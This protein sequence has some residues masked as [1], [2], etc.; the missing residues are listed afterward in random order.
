VNII[1]ENSCNSRL[2][3]ESVTAPGPG[4]AQAA[5]GLLGILPRGFAGIGGGFGCRPFALEKGAFDRVVFEHQA[6]HPVDAVYGI[7]NDLEFLV[8]LLS[9]GS[10]GIFFQLLGL[11]GLAQAVQQGASLG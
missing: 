4:S 8:A 3:D 10:F 6:A 7:I 2:K 5:A 9:G 1:R 11:V